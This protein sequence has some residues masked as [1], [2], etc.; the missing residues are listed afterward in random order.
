MLNDSHYAVC[1]NLRIAVLDI[2]EDC[3]LE[4]IV[5]YA[6]QLTAYKIAAAHTVAFLVGCVLPDFAVDNLVLALC[7][8]STIEV[9]DKLVG[10]LVRNVKSPAC[11]TQVNPLL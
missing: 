3:L 5:H 9:V 6:V 4:R 1:K 10:K 7:L 2:I 11:R 8:Y